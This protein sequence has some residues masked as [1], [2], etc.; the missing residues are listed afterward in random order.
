MKSWILAGRLVLVYGF[1]LATPKALYGLPNVDEPAVV[2][3]EVPDEAMVLSTI[4]EQ[5]DQMV[6]PPSDQETVRA[7]ISAD[8]EIQASL[9]SLPVS[10]HPSE[11][12]LRSLMLLAE[13]RQPEAIEYLRAT[14]ETSSARRADAARAL[15]VAIRDQPVEAEDWQFLVRSL[16]VVEGD[17]AVDVLQTLLRFQQR[18]TRGH[19]VRQ[20]ILIGL[21]LPEDQQVTAV[22]LLRHWTGVPT[23][24]RKSD[25]WTLAEYQAWFAKEFTDLPPAVLPQEIPNRRWTE[26][27]VTQLVNESAWTPEMQQTATDAYQKANCQRCHKRG[28]SGDKFGPDLTTLGWRRNRREIIQSILFPSHELHEEYPTVVVQ[29]KDG[30]QVSGIMSS[31]PENRLVIQSAD[32]KTTEFGKD[33]VE[34]I[35]QQNVSNMPDGAFELLSPEQIAA[36]ILWLERT[37]GVPQPHLP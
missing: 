12:S 3:E 16:N 32:L 24:R 31:V 4:R 2:D 11:S 8:A 36:L 37:D 19:W 5:L 25:A 10:K 28:D 29:L 1:L 27:A 35:R 23:G 20:V 26:S 30:R 6:E 34:E 33:D 18:A 9:K 13:S 17:A 14:F 22:Q 21:G 7:L 15:A